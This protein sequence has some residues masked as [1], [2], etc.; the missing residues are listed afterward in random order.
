M[1]DFNDKESELDSNASGT[2][3]TPQPSYS[4]EQTTILS[5]E[6]TDE[7]IGEHA[8]FDN[9]SLFA[10]QTPFDSQDALHD[11]NAT[12][13]LTQPAE[14][15]Y[16]TQ[17]QVPPNNSAYMPRK[18]APVWIFA[19]LGALIILG[20]GAVASYV[21][22][23]SVANAFALA[24]MSAKD[25]YI[26]VESNNIK[27]A[28]DIISDGYGQILD[29]YNTNEGKKAAA[30]NFNLKLSADPSF[31]NQFNITNLAP[32]ELKSTI[33][34]KDLKEK[35]NLSLLYNNT[36]LLSANT[37]MD[38]SQEN[39]GD[40]Y[41]QVPELSDGN[42][43]MKL[44]ELAQSDSAAENKLSVTPNEVLEKLKDFPL[45]E[46]LLNQLINRYFTTMIKEV[47]TVS[48][49]KKEKLTAN[50]MSGNYTK[51]V[52]TLNAADAMNMAKA[53]LAVAKDDSDLIKLCTDLELCSKEEFSSAIEL[54]TLGLSAYSSSIRSTDT[55]DMILWVDPN[56]I[57]MGR[58][59][60]SNIN[61]ANCQLGYKS[62][63]SKGSFGYEINVSQNN[64][65]VFSLKGSCNK[66]GKTK[67]GSM[68]I[69][70]TAGAETFTGTV[71]FDNMQ[72]HNKEKGYFS[73]NI[74][75]T[76]DALAGG[77]LQI[78]A[79]GSKT[80][81]KVTLDYLQDEAKTITLESTMEEIKCED[82]AY[83]PSGT[84]YDIT[85][86]EDMNTFLST[87]KLEDFKT[88][89]LSALGSDL[90]DALSSLINGA[91]TSLFENS[92]NPNPSTTQPD[93]PDAVIIP[94]PTSDN[95][96]TQT[97]TIPEDVEI[98]EDGYYS[99]E[100]TTQEV[101]ARKEASSDLSVYD[102]TK[103]DILP[104]LRNIVSNKLEAKLEEG[105]PE[106]YNKIMGC[107]GDYKYETKTFITSV[108]FSAPDDYYPSLKLT[109][110]TYTE[111]VSD[112]LVQT[113]TEE[114]LK[115]VL[116]EVLALVEGNLSEADVKKIQ[117]Q[118]KVADGDN[119]SS[120]SFGNS[121]IYYS[122]S[123][124]GMYCSISAQ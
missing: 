99:Y 6:S 8:G 24:T 33:S 102:V 94:E 77:K 53:A 29:A 114:E 64:A 44:N 62:V 42:L 113:K 32:I 52:V 37:F 124:N 93:D 106:A 63:H 46:K 88:K 81:Q 34:I 61:G 49:T 73:G 65:S 89:L 56:G 117:K 26:K 17:Q 11:Q 60:I 10:S 18:K 5:N 9:S 22:I 70:C 95:S 39:Y 55:L 23:P 20:A 1:S 40:T 79:T 7:A 35:L 47:N 3:E 71:S 68:D 16:S 28:S 103:D 66:K 38:L 123:E 116:P 51:I 78:V 80:S 87:L 2:P 41:L 107:T 101:Q 100:I 112:F 50:G 105:E 27:A 36:P 48:L 111:K 91:N 72:I 25:Y 83:P 14:P 43:F 84:I 76:S 57:V 96:N 30:A 92:L 82:F 15:D 21:F 19:L 120:F 75:L 98:D 69:S 90:T 118:L 12:Q 85:N 115:A 45:T 59:I 121:S 97:G 58:E 54:A 13:V 119:Y 86:Q 31:T 109:Y 4:A 104:K 74:T 110:D 67:Q 122:P 108:T